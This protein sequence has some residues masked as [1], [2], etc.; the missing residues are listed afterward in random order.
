MFSGSF[1]RR[2]EIRGSVCDFID[3]LRK[4]EDTSWHVRIAK[5]RAELIRRQN[6]VQAAPLFCP[7]SH[8]SRY[9]LSLSFSTLLF[10]IVKGF[11]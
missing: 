4:R 9:S 2:I 11:N 10:V 5:L 6:R 3:A 8:S 7:F 1:P